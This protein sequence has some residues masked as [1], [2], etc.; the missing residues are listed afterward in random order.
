[1][2]NAI[3]WGKDMD[4]AL[5]HA[6]SQ[7]LP[8]LLFFH[9]PGCPGCQQ[10]DAVTFPDRKVIDFVQKNYIPLQV[11]FDSR[12]FS[13]D[14]NIKWTPTI[15]TLGVDLGEHHRTVGFLD[16]DAFIASFLLGLGKYHFDNERFP[17]ALA[18]FEQIIAERP[19][20][21]STAEAIYLRG[22]SLYKKSGDRK[23]LKETYE[24]LSSRFPD[25]EWTR[26]AYPYRL[27]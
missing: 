3:A 5:A 10:M 23:P 22:V 9:N 20:S 1:M 15:I 12:P 6:R 26:R 4:R 24:I 21:A 2:A 7:N 11:P 27:L 19:R 17:E 8:I 14:F 16:P 13:L 18:F 25:S